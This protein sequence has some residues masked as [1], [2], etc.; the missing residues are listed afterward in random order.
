M[1]IDYKYPDN[2]M[3]TFE[4]KKEKVIAVLKENLKIHQE[5]YKKAVEEFNTAAEK[6][7]KERLKLIRKHGAL[8]VAYASNL[9]MYK[10]IDCTLEYTD[11]IE[12]LEASEDTTMKLSQSDY[13]KYFL[14]RWGNHQFN[15]NRG[16]GPIAVGGGRG[17]A[18][19]GVY[20]MEADYSRL[21]SNS[22]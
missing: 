10:P 6:E 8:N 1:Y 22:N 5:N 20:T 15:R 2:T 4:V 18:A 13:N 17:F 7:V 19:P 16:G 14:D 12:L 9:D 3:N 21:Y 11:L